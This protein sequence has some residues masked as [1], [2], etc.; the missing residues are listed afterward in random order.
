MEEDPVDIQLAVL[1]EIS[2]RNGTPIALGGKSTRRI[3]GMLI[4]A[5]GE[6]VSLDQLTAAT[7]PDT[8]DFDRAERNLHSYL[9]RLRSRFAPLGDQI[10]ET[11]PRGYAIGTKDIDS[12][13]YEDH[14]RA[15]FSSLD[16]GDTASALRQLTQA[17]KLWTDP[18]YGEFCAELWA[19]PEVERLRALR[20]RVLESLAEVQLQGGNVEDA[21]SQAELVFREDPFREAPRRIHMTALYRSG[22]AVEAMRSFQA[23]RTLLID[24]VGA[25]PSATLVD[26]DRRIATGTEPL[27]VTEGAKEIRGYQLHELVGSGPTSSV[28]RGIHISLNREVAIKAIHPEF[29]NQAWFIRAFETQTSMTAKLEHPHIVPLYDFWREPGEAFLVM[30]WFPEGSID[31]AAINPWPLDRTI[32]VVDQIGSALTAI[33]RAGL[34]HGAVRPSNI[35]LGADGNYF[36]SDIGVSTIGGTGGANRGYA[37]AFSPPEQHANHASQKGD[38]YSLAATATAMLGLTA[39]NEATEV[40]TGSHLPS[41]LLEALEKA[42]HPDESQRFSSIAALRSAFLHAAGDAGISNTVSSP[43]GHISSES[44]DRSNPYV[45]LR[46]FDEVDSSVFGGREPLIETLLDRFRAD[47]PFL[48]LIGASGSGKSSVV[49]AGLLPELR[50][51][52]VPG[53]REWFITDMSPGRSPFTSLELALLRIAP[54]RPTNLQQKLAGDEGGLLAVAREILGDR[55]AKVF[56]VIDQFEELFTLC[57]NEPVRRRFLSSLA[58]AATEPNSPLRMI[59]TLRADFYD[60]PLRYPGFA[61]LVR[62]G[63]ITITPLTAEQLERAITQP[64]QLAGRSFEKGLVADVLADVTAQPGALPLMQHALSELFESQSGSVL[65]ASTY[66]AV[67][68]LEGALAQSAEAVFTSSDSDTRRVTKDLFSRMVTLGEG[69][70][71]TRRRVR[72]SEL[73]THPALGAVIER[74]VQRR[75]ITVD[76][77]TGTRENTLEVTH[78][79]LIREWPRLRDWLDEDRTVL[80]DHRLLGVAAREWISTGCRG[81]DLYRGARLE[82]VDGWLDSDIT[83][84]SAESQFV[85]ESIAAR[86]EAERLEQERLRYRERQNRRL[87]TLLATVG[88]VAV[89]ALLAGGIALQQRQR[90]EEQAQVANESAQLSETRRLAADAA[91]LVET[92]RRLALL[93]AAEAHRR[94]PGVESLGALQQ[95][96]VGSDNLIGYIGG[97]T[98]YDAV[99]FADHGTIA[100]ATPLAIEA[101]SIATNELTGTLPIRNAS[102]LA[103]SPDGRL[104]AAGS[105]SGFTLW[106]AASWNM[107]S[108]E[109]LNSGEVQALA[110]NPDGTLVAAGHRDGVVRVFSTATYEEVLTIDAHIEQSLADLRHEEAVSLISQH[111]PAATGR[112]TLALSFDSTGTLLASGGW[113]WTRTWSIPSGSLLGEIPIIRDSGSQRVVDTA[114][115]VGFVSDDE[116]VL[117]LG[118]FV[119]VIG[120]AR[121]GAL[122]VSRTIPQRESVVTTDLS[123]ISKAIVG[124]DFGLSAISGREIDLFDLE[125]FSGPTLDTHLSSTR[126]LALRSD[127]GAVAAA[128][129]DGIAILSLTKD[130]LLRRFVGPATGNELAVSKDGT[131]VAVGSQLAGSPQA[132][133]RIEEDIVIELQ[134]PVETDLLYSRF[135]PE[136][137]VIVYLCQPQ[138]DGE[139][140]DARFVIFDPETSEIVGEFPAPD[141]PAAAAISPDGQIFAFTDADAS[142]YAVDLDSGEVLWEFD[143]LTSNEFVLVRSLNFDPNSKHLAASTGAGASAIFDLTTGEQRTIAAGGGAAVQINFGPSP[144]LITTAS[145]SG[146]FTVRRLVDLQPTG[147]TLVGQPDASGGWH[148]P[149]FLEIESL[150]IATNGPRAELF[151]VNTGLAIGT[152]FPGSE[153]FPTGSSDDG[154][155]LVSSDGT[156]VFT[157]EIDPQRWPEIACQA[158]GRNLT[159]AEWE[160]FGPIGQPYA[161]TCSQY[162]SLNNSNQEAS[163]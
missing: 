143:A 94:D 158:A 30:R 40:N 5:G 89:L 50:N 13:L 102:V 74:F 7:W 105:S 23:F 91:Q 15:G 86:D 133:Y 99:A 64:A 132:L 110:F 54:Q 129:D 116:E 163:Q 136:N 57:E 72:Q 95:A 108:A 113:G 69:T 39:P 51:G 37:N 18:P 80:R 147:R 10:I 97:G 92:D 150:M 125:A 123:Q 119:T 134:I 100:A 103:T 55:D 58:A 11:R 21:I 42:T 24:N 71:D 138:C 157:F 68:G 27:Q 85:K 1:G 20:L 139:D 117:T 56:I 160:S 151:D 137:E 4:M 153:D 67:G 107:E 41:A 130:G 98:S 36:L 14:A 63:G 127:D 128:S 81:E 90:A 28:Y 77:D 46:A 31:T 34:V 141:V 144:D 88:V 60:H 145:E 48:A 35:L 155:Y 75:L 33:H 148:G 104:L 8:D 25:E 26:L 6:T 49:R 118:R 109:T 162:P 140:R 82:N 114:D 12:V 65:E 122:S 52:A 135:G 2:A 17:T 96:L 112:G 149:N 84:N 76:R 152:P 61:E 59:L 83:L 101:W 45:G 16:A 73:P 78:E 79:A 32:R 62:D 43:K 161:A 156:G 87:R 131:L 3:L 154:R 66:R 22:R 70:E 142:I 115:A 9:S 29:V 19:L 121:D 120:S 126:G 44:T 124:T 93:L 38:Q 47:E 53:S 111:A 159:P 106:P 146:Q